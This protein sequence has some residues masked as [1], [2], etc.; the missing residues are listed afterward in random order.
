[1]DHTMFQI[2]AKVTLAR[3]LGPCV[4]G[5]EGRVDAVDAQGNVTV[6]IQFRNPG[7]TPFVFVLPPSPPDYFNLGGGCS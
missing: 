5:D 4:P 2:G 6:T 1:M 3:P 7:C